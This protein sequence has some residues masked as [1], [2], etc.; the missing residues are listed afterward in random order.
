MLDLT[1]LGV[2]RLEANIVVF[3]DGR[4]NVPTPKKAATPEKTAIETVVD[5]AVRRFEL[6]NG[7]LAFNSQRQAF[8][9]RGTNLRAQLWYSVLKQGYQ[10][11]VALDPLYVISGRNTPVKFTLTLPIALERDRIELH[12]A[13]IST[14][15]SEILI[16]ASIEN[17]RNPKTSAHV[18]GRLAL[19]DLKNAGNLQLDLDRRDLLSTVDLDANA[20]V[21]DNT[22]QVTGLRLTAGHSEITAS[23]KLKDPNGNGALDFKARLAV[24]ELGRLANVAA[25][26]GGTVVLSGLVKLD[27]DNNY[28]VTGNLQAKDLSFQNGARR[29]SGLNLFSGVS[30]DPHRLELRDLR[31]AAFGGE[32]A[33][34]A[35]LEEFARYKLNANLR[36]FDLR[37][38]A[39]AMGQKN[40]AYAGVA[41]GSIAAGG[42]L[43]Q[44]GTRSVTAYAKIS[45]APGRQGIPVSGRLNADYNGAADNVSIT[46][47][48]IALP[49][50]RVTLNGSLGKRLDVALTTRD[51][52]DLL[53]AVPSSSKPKV[54]LDAGGQATL[55]SVV[56]GS[57]TRP[58]VTANLAANRFS[59]DGRRFDALTLD[60]SVSSAG[61]AVSNG[62][63]S[64]GAMQAQFTASVGLQNWKATPSQPL[65]ATASIRNGDLA[66][67]MVLAGQ[68]GADYSGA[69]SANVNVSGTVGNPLG[70]ADLLLAKGTIQGEPFDVI[71][72]R[73]NMADQLITIP[74]A[75]AAA[76]AARLDLTADF[77][78]PR[79]S[80]TSGRLHAHVQSSQV[81]LAQFR[82]V[83]KE[84]PNSA[85]EIQI[86]ADVTGSLSE[87]KSGAARQ[88]EFL[89]T[90]VSADASAR[91]LRF[92]GQD[93]GDF[94]VTA[95]TNDQTVRY[96]VTS[97]FAGSKISANG[98]TKLVREY[99]TTAD[100]S[101]NNLQIE[102]VLALAKR[103]NIP[104]KGNL[105]GS[106][107]FTGTTKNPQGEAD[108]E[109]TSAVLYDEPVDRARARVTYLAESVDIRQLEIV[110]GPARIDLTAKYDHPA[111]NLEAGEASIPPE[112][113]PHRSGAHSKPAEGAAGIRRHGNRRGQRVRDSPARR[114]PSSVPG[115]GRKSGGDRHR[116]PRQ[117]LR[118]SDAYREHHRRTAEPRPGFE[119][120]GGFHSWARHC[121]P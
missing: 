10:G 71:Q 78:H 49:H 33:G 107:H 61:A 120:G 24:G 64:R 93:Y 112:Q 53:A 96:S 109:L 13:K 80:F 99:P 115:A 16:N 60:A 20:T 39:S 26:P 114:E 43:K 36:G 31:L 105:S 15:S 117:E 56:T 48:Y 5:L 94:N 75:H 63:L 108:L 69:L 81:N 32:A 8:N 3:P 30:L 73:V 11:Q 47:S 68:P 18:Q 89:L 72:A 102:R 46:D 88:V 29:I 85:G 14:P 70:T 119:P 50:T 79:E 4:T 45:I 100:A 62:S 41:S 21:A 6:T 113:Q 22:I 27:A 44:P 52:N 98:T 57:L 90:G 2:D 54:A 1:Y 110:S 34:N 91:S 116:G 84:L 38:A 35:S 97:N 95:R 55:T 83:Q 86:Q 66:D 19:A 111:G 65:T 67:I 103:S 82:T 28:Q 40:L 7:V 59:V 25:R 101:I 121:G 12:D 51:L 17:L 58:R 37:T 87:V 106:V 9:I 104:A 92:K 118:R 23:G 77:Q 74:A 42:D 76:G